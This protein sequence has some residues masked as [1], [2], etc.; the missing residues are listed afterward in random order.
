MGFRLAIIPLRELVGN[1][2][3]FLPLGILLGRE[4]FWQGRPFRM[5][6]TGALLSTFLEI[7]QWTTGLGVADVDDV[8]CNTLGAFLGWLPGQKKSRT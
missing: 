1:V 6:L 2:L 3:L 8:L 5:L 4:K 7:L